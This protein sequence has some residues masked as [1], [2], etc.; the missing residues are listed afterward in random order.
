MMKRAEVRDSLRVSG[1]RSPKYYNHLAG[2]KSWR[3]TGEMDQLTKDLVG[4][5]EEHGIY[6]EGHREP[7][8]DLSRRVT[9]SDLRFGR[10]TPVENNWKRE[11]V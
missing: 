1:S 10:N 6:P 11:I 7:L 3:K 5:T 9:Q 2:A 8:K 4:H